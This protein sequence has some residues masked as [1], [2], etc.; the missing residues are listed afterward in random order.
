MARHCP[1]C[2]VIM[3]QLSFLDV[4]VDTCPQC[5]GIFFDEG[6]VSQIRARGGEKAF[7]DL[8]SIVQPAPDYV[9]HEGSKFRRCPNCQSSMHRYRYMYASPIFLD[10][11]ESCGGVFIE[12]GE[13]KQMRDYLHAEKPSLKPEVIQER[14]EAIATLDAMITEQHAKADRARWGI[15]AMAFYP[16]R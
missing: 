5:A 14:N 3:T 10:S 2:D 7:D 11:C 9:P 4:L 6:E 15:N 12:D 16:W 1:D 13:L 8:D